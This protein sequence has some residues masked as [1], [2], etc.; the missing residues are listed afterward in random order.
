MGMPE[1]ARNLK[2]RESKMLGMVIPDFSNPVYAS[3]IHGAEDQAASE[4]YNLL[5]YSLKQ[6]GLDKRY[7][8][9]LLED[10]IDGLLIANSELDNNDI[11]NLSKT[12]N[13]LSWSIA[14]FLK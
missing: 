9:H 13:H 14:L 10:Q 11:I 5:V 3:I 1:S 12:K 6:K 2:K 7:F 4:G 8:S